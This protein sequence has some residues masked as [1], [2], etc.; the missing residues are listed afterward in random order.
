M[1][2][3]SEGGNKTSKKK[4]R[5]LMATM[6]TQPKYR[7]TMQRPNGKTQITTPSGKVKVFHATR[8]QMGMPTKAELKKFNS[9]HLVKKATPSISV[10]PVV[11]R[12]SHVTVANRIQQKRSGGGKEHSPQ[13]RGV[14]GDS[15]HKRDQHGNHVKHPLLRRARETIA[16]QINPQ[17]TQY[18]QQIQDTKQ[19]RDQQVGDLSDLYRR[20]GIQIDESKTRGDAANTAAQQSITNNYDELRK[21]LEGTYQ[22]STGQTTAELARLGLGEATPAATGRLTSDQGYLTGLA[23]IDKANAL[24]N[25][26]AQGQSFDN[27]ITILSGQAALSGTQKK[28]TAL[29]TAA[30]AISELR[31]QK[32]ALAATRRGAVD[33]LFH[34]LKDAKNQAQA[35][36]AQQAFMNKIAAGKLGIEQGN[37]AIAQG[38][39]GVEQ[40]RLSLDAANSS[41]S[42]D[43]KRAQALKYI[44]DAKA[45][46][47]SGSSTPKGYTGGLNF[48]MGTKTG[49]NAAAKGALKTAVSVYKT[50]FTHHG[51][52]ALTELSKNIKSGA[53]HDFLALPRD[54]QGAIVDALTIAGAK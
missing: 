28:A 37:L 17:L 36:A 5:K 40:G 9:N 6:L 52:L 8:H 21:Q 35:D 30:N 49:H 34:Q 25:S 16:A 43:L 44:R 19:Q 48:L 54:L 38:K 11:G 20:L 13:N 14:G 33:A 42:N 7:T 45:P 1:G 29:Q 15:K 27:L 3:P 47:T 2:L 53:A 39:L 32:G 10:P 51:N 23:G 26:T 31:S 18:K 41:V 50:Y 24:S 4:A 46:Y 12:T 22:S